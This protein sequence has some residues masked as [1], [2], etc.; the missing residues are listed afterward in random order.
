MSTKAV[1]NSITRRKILKEGALPASALK[2]LKPKGMKKSEGYLVVPSTS[3]EEILAKNEYRITKSD[4]ELKLEF[5]SEVPADLKQRAMDWAKKK[6]LNVKEAALA[7]SENAASY[8]IF[9]L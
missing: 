6:K 1:S 2:K 3:K 5:G 9:S 7:K 8:I 4:R